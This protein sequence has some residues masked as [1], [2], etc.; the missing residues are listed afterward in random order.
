MAKDFG[1]R[2][3][4][5]AR[6]VGSLLV[7]M[8]LGT[9]LL[10]LPGMSTR[11]L[12]FNDAAFMAVSAITVTGLATVNVATD[13]TLA[14]QVVLLLLTQFGGVGYIVVAVTV[15]SL[16]GRQVSLTDRVALQ[17]ALGDVSP[18]GLVQLGRRVFLG[19][20]VFEGLGA[21]LLYAHWSRFIDDP[22][23]P[24][25]AVFTSVVS[26]CNAGFDPFT[27]DPRYSAGM[28]TD[29]TTLLIM[30]S[31]IV[32][33]GIGFPV[34]HEVFVERGRKRFSLHTRLTLIVSAGLIVWGAFGLMLSET[35]PGRI[36]HGETLVRQLELTTFQSVSART[37]GFVGM[38]RFETLDPASQ[39]MILTL[40][41]VGSSPASM[42]GGATT[43]TFVVM[44]LALFA[45]LR[46]QSA[47]V[48]GGRAIPGAMVRK[49]AA[50]LTISLFVVLT[51][52]WLLMLTHPV[53]LDRAVF[54]SV[55][56]F[57]TCGLSL[58]FTT[59]L[60]WF[61]QAVVMVTMLWGR[62]GALT[63]LVILTR[64]DRPTRLF[65]PEERVLIG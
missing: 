48:V 58:G 24:F 4:V 41:F 33:G 16:L 57:A 26:F 22:M 18:R 55:S 65:Y 64:R 42:G 23:L 59:E 34:L 44:V 25:K 10:M 3:P 32:L 51:S 2:I 28:P 49:A 6:L 30:G 40:M 62:L 46:G 38:P 1:R 36:L 17:D 63:L 19:V 50:V 29:G 47:P 61:G 11:G 60:N 52:A 8:L 5:V 35:G 53:S 45:Y 37:A 7:L 14:G 31:L 39:M 20:V 12:A 54:E 15:F 21:L 27:G 56:A 13:L 43:G 9:G